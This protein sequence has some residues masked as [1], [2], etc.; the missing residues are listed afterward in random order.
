M[1]EDKVQWI[2]VAVLMA[3]L[4]AGGFLFFRAGVPK[5][6]STGPPPK[7]PDGPGQRFEKISSGSTNSGDV[8]VELTPHA[9]L[10]GGKMVVDISV[11]THSVDLTRF[12]LR[13][14]T[15][16]E[17]GAAS[18]RPVSALKLEGHHNS[19]TLVFETGTM[20]KE[21]TIRIRGIPAVEER[22]FTW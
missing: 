2:I 17:Y 4:V 7:N 16:L 12:D 1:D 5:P 10:E 6:E 18:L 15:L 13:G 14:L 19:G 8:S 20:P 11:N 21:F 9:S 3:A 22:V